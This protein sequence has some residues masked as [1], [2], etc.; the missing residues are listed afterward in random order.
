MDCTLNGRCACG[1]IRYSI[2]MPARE[3]LHCHCTICRRIH[4]AVFASFASVPRDAVDIT[5]GREFLTEFA[6]SRDVRRYFCRTCGSHL[7]I[8]D[9]RTPQFTWYSVGTL[10]GG[11]PGHSESVERHVFLE[12]RVSWF[13]FSDPQVCASQVLADQPPS[14]AKG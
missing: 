6:S 1:S 2:A 8:E 12:S 13:R 7:L 3:I 14:R 11:H 9:D 4:G 10:D 5:A